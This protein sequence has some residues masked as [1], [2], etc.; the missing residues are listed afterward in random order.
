MHGACISHEIRARPRISRE[1]IQRQRVALELIARQAG[2]H[3]IPRRVRSATRNG[4]H[5]IQRRRLRSEMRRAVY[6][7]SSAVAHRGAFDRSLV[8]ARRTAAA[9]TKIA[10]RFAR[11]HDV[12]SATKPHCPS[13]KTTTPPQGPDALRGCQSVGRRWPACEHEVVALSAFAVA[14]RRVVAFASRSENQ[15]AP[16]RR[17]IFLLR[18]TKDARG[19]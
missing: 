1:E 13:P 11:R 5:M 8:M 19:E 2:D 15:P 14:F 18:N 10:A 4:Q 7:A 12:E 16:L 6:A 3:E 9:E 17:A